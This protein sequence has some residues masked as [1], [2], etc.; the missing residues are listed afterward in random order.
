MKDSFLERAKA[1]GKV[2]VKMVNIAGKVGKLKLDIRQKKQ[3]R[4]RQFH[5][6]GV[7]IYEL[8]RVKGTI[9]GQ[10]LVSAV[11]DDLYAIKKLDE[12]IDNLESLVAQ[13]RAQMKEKG[14]PEEDSND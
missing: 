10:D 4:D 5:A 2:F 11:G 13:A 3:Q 1:D 14:I 9:V 12:E 6:V 7:A 8:N